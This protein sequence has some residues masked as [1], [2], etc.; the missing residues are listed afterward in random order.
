MLNQ[1]KIEQVGTPDEIYDN[2]AS[3]FVAGFIGESNALPV[4]ADAG[5][6][7]LDDR[8]LDL[9]GAAG[10]SGPRVLVFRPH[11]VDVLGTKPGGIAGSVI[12]ER[13]HG[14]VRRL[15]VEISASRHRIEVDVR[16]DEPKSKKG[17]RISI[18]P[19][20]WWLFDEGKPS[21]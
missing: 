7:L 10:M 19:N 13:R 12:S 17:D 20:R 1:G 8:A 5:N 9:A 21:T 11:H 6:L 15:E 3:P 2:P 18:L 4:V 16:A 14:A